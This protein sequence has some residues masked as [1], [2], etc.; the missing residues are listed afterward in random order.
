MSSIETVDGRMT[1]EVSIPPEVAGQRLDP[2]SVG[3][4]VDGNYVV[5]NVAR[6]RGDDLAV[7]LA[8]DVSGSTAGPVLEQAV[9]AAA[10][11]VDSV[12]E[13]TLIGVVSFA[14][15][16]LVLVQPTSDLSV[17][18]AALASLSGDGPTALFD[19]LVTSSQVIGTTSATS[20]VVVVFSDGGDTNSTAT[21]ADATAASAAVDASV[22][23]VSLQSTDADPGTLAA[24]ARE[25][26]VWSVADPAALS[27][28][29]VDI[30]DRLGNRFV[31][32][33]DE[34]AGG[35]YVVV[36]GDNG[37]R[38]TYV[39][40]DEEVT[41]LPRSDAGSR[42]AV[43][44]LVNRP[45][46][47]PTVAEA[48]TAMFGDRALPYGLGSV[49]AAVFLAAI[50]IAWPNP[51]RNRPA[52]PMLARRSKP[53]PR[54]MTRRLSDLAESGLARSGRKNAIASMLEQ[55]GSSLRVGEWLV[56][57]LGVA[58]GVMAGVTV[59]A[60][61]VLGLVASA[62]VPLLARS[63]LKLKVAKTRNAFADQLGSTLQLMA[64]NLRV[65]HGMLQSIDAVGR[66][67]DEPTSHEFRRVTGEIRLGRDVGDALRA[68]ADRLDNDDFR[69]VVQ[70][71]EIH[72][73]VGG[74]LG[75]VLDNVGATI[76]DRQRLKG[77]IA[78]LSADGRI[79]AGV[80]MA[81]PFCVGG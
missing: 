7:V 57:V 38:R 1:L 39:E 16:P 2:S 64:S 44:E 63:L 3:V 35:F 43:P 4:I 66:E 53:S 11:F 70:A 81:L 56:A 19:G 47:V 24:L 69:W 51:N 68:M 17:V 23:V 6:P 67:S 45:S 28:V 32:S 76:R 10:R 41:G 48:P 60:G 14:E 5:A 65:G 80:M 27:D 33:F 21:L 22:E 15:Q 59:A 49:A 46:V 13:G 61:P 74:D 31:V 54:E 37:L 52:R 75:E 71:V 78:A 29:F 62:F 30:G 8:M 20:R 25:G 34:P 18:Q 9:T 50:V 73:E 42:A 26:Q 55:S 58:M 40:L 36:R 72:R 77:Q 79:S 12:P